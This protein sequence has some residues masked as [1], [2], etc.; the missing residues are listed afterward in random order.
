MNAM[1]QGTKRY[2]IRANAFKS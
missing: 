1:C 2:E